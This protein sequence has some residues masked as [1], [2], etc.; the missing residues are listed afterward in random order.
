MLSLKA[1]MEVDPDLRA[2]LIDADEG[3]L[4]PGAL[5]KVAAASQ[6]GCKAL[7]NQLDKALR[8]QGMEHVRY[9][10]VNPLSC[11]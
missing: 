7:L 9:Q 2:S 10:H 8:A 11:L 1:K 5:P 4:R 3:L 6:Q